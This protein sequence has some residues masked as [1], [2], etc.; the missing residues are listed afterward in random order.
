M[1]TQVDIPGGTA[2]IRSLDEMTVRQRRM[3]QAT[4]MTTSHIYAQVPLELLEAA[5]SESEKLTPENLEARTKIARMIAGLRLTREDAEAFLGLQD[6]AIVAFLA[7]WSL[8][9][10]LPTLDTVQDLSPD[11]YDALAVATAPAAA[12]LARGT[13]F[14]EPTPQGVDSPFG[15]SKTSNNGS[16][17][18]SDIQTPTSR[19]TGRRAKGGGNI[20]TEASIPV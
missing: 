18:E 14:G 10:T 4:S 6:A 7:S 3:I 2:R 12:K 20:D 19:S 8:E 15:S 16:S 9:Q 5:Q 11:L 17:T 1:S 13:A